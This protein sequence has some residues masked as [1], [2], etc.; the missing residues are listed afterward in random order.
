MEKLTEV[1]YDENC[2]FEHQNWKSELDF[3]K[4]ELK[5]F[6]N[7]LSELITRGTQKDVLKQLEHFQNEFILHGGVID[8]LQ[9]TIEKHEISIVAHSKE[10]N[11]SMDFALVKKHMKFRDRIQT[12][13]LIYADLKKEFFSFLTKYM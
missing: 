10:G 6:N 8:D 5:I 9:E 7:R 12:Q 4:D 11:E 2:H 13:R 3:W 1:V